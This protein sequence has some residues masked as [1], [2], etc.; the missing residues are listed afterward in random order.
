MKLKILFI[1]ILII[2]LSFGQNSLRKTNVYQGL[3]TKYN[4]EKIEMYL[5]FLVLSDSTIIGIS[6]YKE[7]QWL[8][9]NLKGKLF[10]DN[11]F[12]LT[13]S[14]K[15]GVKVDS[16]LGKFENNYSTIKVKFISNKNEN[17]N[18]F[19]ISQKV[20]SW[21]DYIT[22]NR[23]LFEYSDLKKSIK[24]KD[25]VLS[26]DVA[27]QELK[28]IPKRLS[29]L[30]KIVS[31]NLLGNKFERFPKVLTKLQTLDE[32]SL[33]SNKLN[34]IDSEIGELKNLRI[35]ILNNN[36]LKE[37]PNEIGKLESL[38]YLEIGNNQLTSLP[39][40]ISHL[41]NLQELH[42]E[43]NNLSEIEKDRIKKL[44]PKCKIHF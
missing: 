25:K 12:H 13:E 42:I 4:S 23:Y 22:K 2:Q 37:L 31:I 29:K 20:I 38:M 6:L 21:S 3:I 33:S 19:E 35:L 7:P 14:D 30:N 40:E 18:E 8:T 27:H 34:Y 39:E 15:S 5:N 44:L 16:L 17:E 32:I 24:A 28:K 10:S 41:T 1:L 43:R 11:T 9:N 26:I 36:Q